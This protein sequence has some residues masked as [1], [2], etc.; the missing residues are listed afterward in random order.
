MLKNLAWKIKFFELLDLSLI[1]LYKK[2]QSKSVMKGLDRRMSLG[3]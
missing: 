2:I 1:R 3:S